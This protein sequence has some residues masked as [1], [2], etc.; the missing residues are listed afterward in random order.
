VNYVLACGIFAFAPDVVSRETVLGLI[1]TSIIFE[2]SCE[3]AE[4]SKV[5]I[6]LIGKEL[7]RCAHLSNSLT[8]PNL[9]GRVALPMLRPALFFVRSAVFGCSGIFGIPEI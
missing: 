3:A 5:A 9:K 1:S 2:S 7:S 8:S 4:T 6:A